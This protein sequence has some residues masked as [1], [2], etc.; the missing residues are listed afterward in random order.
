M[1]AKFVEKLRATPDGDG[2]LLDHSMVLFG[3]GMG[4]AND[5]THHPLPTVVL[6]GGGGQMKAIGQHMAYPGEPMANLLL[7]LAQ[8]T[9]APTERFGAEHRPLDI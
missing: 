3:S 8:K 5:H 6:G 2:T 4:N 7:A 1:F 9:G